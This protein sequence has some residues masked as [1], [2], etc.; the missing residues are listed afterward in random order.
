MMNAPFEEAVLDLHT[1]LR[2][3]LREK[4]RSKS[5]ILAI[6]DG[7]LVA[8]VEEVGCHLELGEVA[9][10]FRDAIGLTYGP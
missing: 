5:R 8:A 10:I 1:L 2:C 7:D 4:I 6:G 9:F 3:R